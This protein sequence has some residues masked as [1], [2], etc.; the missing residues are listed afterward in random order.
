MMGISVYDTTM[1]TTVA[2]LGMSDVRFHTPLFDGDTLRVETEIAGAR[3]SKSNPALGIVD[4]IHRGYNQDGKLIGEFR[5][6]GMMVK[7]PAG[8]AAEGEQP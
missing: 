1:G 5:R 7:A 4:F 6:Q 2:N 8:D 3:E